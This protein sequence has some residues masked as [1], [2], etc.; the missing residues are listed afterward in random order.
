MGT[1][2]LCTS[3][4]SKVDTPAYHQAA[5]LSL[6]LSLQMPCVPM[7]Q[8]QHQ[9]RPH[10]FHTPKFLE[11]LWKWAFPQQVP[12]G[13][14]YLGCPGPAR[15][16]TCQKHRCHPAP[17]PPLHSQVR[18]AESQALESKT[19]FLKFSPLLSLH[20][21]RALFPGNIFHPNVQGSSI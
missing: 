11:M 2:N 5:P 17:L 1:S 19:P 10:S 4:Q 14:I 16:G 15:R 6:I 9:G 3:S 20:R 8:Q 7:L 18:E 12:T 13:Q 21:G